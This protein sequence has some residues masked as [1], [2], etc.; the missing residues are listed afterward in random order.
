MNLGNPTTMD[1]QYYKSLH[2][3][4]QLTRHVDNGEEY[5][6]AEILDLPGCMADGATP[7]EAMESV[8]E[9]KE[10]WISA[11]LEDGYEVPEP[12]D[13][14]EFSGRFVLRIPK[15]LHRS[16]ALEAKREGVSLNQNIMTRLAA[17][18]GHPRP[19]TPGV[20]PLRTPGTA[21]GPRDGF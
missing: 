16:L 1:I 10:L 15:S 3:P 4:A 8:E 13:A 7:N 5:W 9:A 21:S 2:Y 17:T 18:A 20:A 19:A 12:S 14:R 6:L 11:H